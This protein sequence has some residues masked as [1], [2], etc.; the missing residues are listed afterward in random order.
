[1]NALNDLH[2]QFAS[3]DNPDS[4]E[5]S[6]DLST[7]S[8]YSLA[9][10]NAMN[11]HLNEIKSKDSI[12]S[13]WRKKFREFLLTKNNH[14]LEFLTKKQKVHPC[15]SPC[16]A[17]FQKYG[18]KQGEFHK[19]I[20]DLI[21]D[22]SNNDIE[23]EV[24]ALCISNEFETVE[25]YIDQTKFFMEEY[26]LYGDKIIDSEKLLKMKLDN[27]ESIQKKVNGIMNLGENEHLEELYKSTE[28]YLE[29]V[30]NQHEI[31]KDYNEIIDNYRKF[32]YYKN[33][34]KLIR[35]S[36]ATE[37]EPLCSICFDNTVSYT[38]VPCGHTFCSGCVLRQGISCALCRSVIRE[39]IKIYFS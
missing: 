38:I 12:N 17:F 7:D 21:S 37:K 34:V 16:E 33:I 1:M 9:L 14:I 19:S 6:L 8:P 39:K 13:T 23:T 27:L 35:L 20:K 31:E 2:L 32:L 26:K 10:N 30:F 15:L 18:S 11:I 3:I 5:A 22:L 4:I 24:N 29:T 28:K 36:E 25:K